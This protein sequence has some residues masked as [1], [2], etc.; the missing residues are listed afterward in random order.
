M[1]GLCP[2]Y[3]NCSRTP[4]WTAAKG[5]FETAKT[6]RCLIGQRIFPFSAWP[7]TMP[8]LYLDKFSGSDVL[9][10]DFLYNGPHELNEDKL[11]EESLKLIAGIA[12]NLY[13]HA[14]AL[15]V[16]E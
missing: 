10:C 14:I 16:A 15:P 9:T 7:A 4:E 11:R 5:N 6:A 8:F 2:F 12:V 1:N 3:V 13:T